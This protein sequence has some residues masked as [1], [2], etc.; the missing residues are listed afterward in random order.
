MTHR[1]MVLEEG[2]AWNGQNYGSLSEI[3][4]PDHRH[5][6]V[7]AALLRP[8]AAGPVMTAVRRCAV[9]TRKSSRRA[10]NRPSIPCMPNGRPAR[11]I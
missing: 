8:E 7:R 5:P 4:H 11:P 2:F 6:L 9:Y 3:A 10:W 1:V